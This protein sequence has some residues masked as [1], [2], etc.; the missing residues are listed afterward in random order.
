MK[1]RTG[2]I[3]ILVLFMLLAFATPV[4]A[5]KTDGQW[6]PA[7]MLKTGSM[8]GYEA[9]IYRIVDHV[10]VQYRD[11]IRILEGDTL[12]IGSQSFNIYSYNIEDGVWSSKTRVAITHY[13][14]IWSIPD[15]SS[16][17]GFSGNI[18]VKYYNYNPFTNTYSFHEYSCVLQG[19]GDFADQTLMLSSEGPPGSDWTGYCLKG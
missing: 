5:E 8:T 2:I 6:V 9:P 13:S 1:K 14:A 15:Q 17:S 19:F 10:I 18:N 16:D 4:L 3:S 12:V 11:G 7:K